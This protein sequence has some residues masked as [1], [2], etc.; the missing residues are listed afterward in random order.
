MASVKNSFSNGI[1]YIKY[2]I[3]QLKEQ[4]AEFDEKE[5]GL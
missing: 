1:G 4:K 2:E 5:K 3:N